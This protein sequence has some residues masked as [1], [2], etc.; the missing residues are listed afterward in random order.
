MPLRLKRD[1]QPL[2]IEMDGDV[3]LFRP[4]GELR[5]QMRA[6]AVSPSGRNAMQQA[7]LMSAEYLLSELQ[8]AGGSM[9]LSNGMHRRNALAR[10]LEL[11]EMARELAAR[12][13]PGMESR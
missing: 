1:N 2:V 13:A 12:D 11:V 5:R 8:K 6:S 9:V 3:F 4:I 10:A 7:F